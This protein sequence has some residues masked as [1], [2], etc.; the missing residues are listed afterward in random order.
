MY[1]GESF[2]T[3]FVMLWFEAAEA[4][5]EGTAGDKRFRQDAGIRNTDSRPQG[6]LCGV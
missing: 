2:R 4:D 5:P 6:A 1:K 3:L